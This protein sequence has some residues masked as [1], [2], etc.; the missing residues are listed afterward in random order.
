MRDFNNLYKLIEESAPAVDHIAQALRDPSKYYLRVY[1][2]P[3]EDWDGNPTTSRDG[4]LTLKG[5]D[6]GALD[7]YTK[8]YSF[9]LE[10]L[11]DA[12]EEVG[13]EIE[14]IDFR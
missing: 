3:S 12:Y 8:V 5:S 10:D 9:D 7:D 14:E 4:D 2:R 1:T 6:P 13:E 11:I